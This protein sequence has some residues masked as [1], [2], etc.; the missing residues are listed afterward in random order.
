MGLTLITT[1]ANPVISL[2]DAKLH[3][4]E[5][6]DDQDTLIA[7]LVEASTKYA[8]RYTGRAFIDQTWDYYLDEFPADDDGIE[9]P[10]PPLIEVVGV[11][12]TDTAGAEQEFAAADYIVIG[13]HGRDNRRAR[14][15]LPATGT[16]PTPRVAES[17]VRIRFRAGYLDTANSPA[18]DDVDEDIK[19]AIL[20][21]L[22]SLYAH[23]ETVIVGQTATQAPWGAEQLLRMK[24][25]DLSMA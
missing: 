3:L 9:I 1:P 6:D 15:S 2:A 19:A 17:A 4:R 13:A 25:V 14:I 7:L 23:R 22:G 24:R 11:F 18:T 16:W 12:Y 21:H 10:L 8:E 5:V 20:L